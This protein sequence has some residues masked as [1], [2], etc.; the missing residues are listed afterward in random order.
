M[1][2]M[3]QGLKT[4][5]T[6]GVCQFKRLPDWI[7]KQGLGNKKLTD[8]K[9][10]VQRDA[11]TLGVVINANEYF[12]QRVIDCIMH[13]LLLGVK[14]FYF[15]CLNKYYN[16]DVWNDIA[17]ILE[18]NKC[19][20]EVFKNEFPDEDSVLE[21]TSSKMT[22]QWV[23][24]LHKESNY[25]RLDDFVNLLNKTE[26]PKFGLFESNEIMVVN[27]DLYL[28]C[29]GNLRKPFKEKLQDF[30]NKDKICVSV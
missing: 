12:D 6:H 22:S 4:L 21:G 2:Q 13:C 30:D 20:I 8:I 1:N 9:D 26:S 27:R 25:Q 3:V 28:Q 11:K 16:K 15:V 14:E 5:Y 10:Y 17:G 19:T 7:G 18:N 24:L 23:T 29:G